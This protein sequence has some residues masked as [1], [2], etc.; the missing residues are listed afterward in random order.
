[1]KRFSFNLEKVLKL[2]EHNENE[3]KIILGRALSILHELENKLMLLAK[4]L[5][6]ASN[7]QFQP[8]NNVN[9]MQQYMFYI[10]RL[11]NTKE[12]LL[13]ECA[14]AE[15]EVEKARNDFIE[16]SRERKV[17]DKLKEKREK[18]YRKEVQ[19]EETLLLDD[20]FRKTAIRNY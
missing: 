10:L 5:S 1:M 20:T 12:V 3:A 19:R 18:E 4:E 7:A 9:L 15:L 6:S 2:R 11:E 17:L 8:G 16:A 14:K 13:E